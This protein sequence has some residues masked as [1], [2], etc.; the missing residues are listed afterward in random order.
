MSPS[1]EKVSSSRQTLFRKRIAPV[2]GT[3]VSFAGFG[4]DYYDSVHKNWS[5]PMAALLA[6]IWGAVCPW[7]IRRLGWSDA[8]SE[9]RPVSERS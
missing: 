1:E 2:V 8:Q 3:L 6:V 4:W 5:W 7:I 9:D